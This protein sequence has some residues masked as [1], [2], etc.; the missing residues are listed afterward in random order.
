MGTTPIMRHPSLSLITG[1][2][3]GM[4]RACARALGRRSALFLADTDAGALEALAGALREE[5]Y[6]VAG[7]QAAD[8]TR[9]EAPAA[10]VA[11]ARAAGP[12]LAVVHTAGLSPALAPWR[13]ILEV[14]LIATE[15]LLRAFEATP[16]A[17]AAVVL[18]AS[19]AGHMAPAEPALDALLDEPLSPDFLS[20]AE[21]ELKRLSDP[22]DSFGTATPAYGLSKRAV[23]RLCERR[24][25]AWGPL[26]MRLVSLSPG[27]V[28]TPMGRKENADNPRAAAVVQATPVGR[29]GTPLDIAEAV[30]FLTSDRAGF[31]T[32]TDL[33]I[34][35]GVTPLLRGLTS[36]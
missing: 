19:M 17:G 32:G 9:P 28:W 10:L 14:N 27:T 15:R 3:G 36:G 35:G 29:W 22:T 8:L 12:T 25:P 2:C 6:E 34:D 26:G 31:I 11:A 5:G 4:G 23:I 30:D 18:V 7:V 24:A 20:R 33:R 13:P 16:T 1:A 21:A